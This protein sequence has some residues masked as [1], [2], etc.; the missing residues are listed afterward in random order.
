MADG[1]GLM[2]LP[3]VP[4]IKTPNCHSGGGVLARCPIPLVNKKAIAMA[5]RE[6]VRIGEIFDF[7]PLFLLCCMLLYILVSLLKSYGLKTIHHRDI[8]PVK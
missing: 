7:R 2:L 8:Y 6:S 1:S 5:T 3:W 4:A